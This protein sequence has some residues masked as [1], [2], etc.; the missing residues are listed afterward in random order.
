MPAG[1]LFETEVERL[2]LVTGSLQRSG[3]IGQTDREDRIG[4]AF[5]VGR[6]QQKS[7]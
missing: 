2:Q 4:I 6:D 1:I 3:Q 7:H 5:A